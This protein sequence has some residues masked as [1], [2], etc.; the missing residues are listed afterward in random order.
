[1][2]FRSAGITVP[3]YLLRDGAL[4]AV[5]A[6]VDVS[7]EH[8]SPTR[9]AAAAME[10]LMA[11]KPRQESPYQNLWGRLC[12][13]GTGVRSVEHVAARH[14]VVVRLEGRAGDLCDL[15]TDALVLREQQLA[16]TVLTNLGLDA[17]TSVRVLG[18]DGRRVTGPPDVV[19]DASLLATPRG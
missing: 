16:W 6:P 18:P 3:M 5:P 14:L 1:M 13:L 7:I 9:R 17:T 12:R 10:A 11:V 15:R 19:P 2:L 8:G 4:V